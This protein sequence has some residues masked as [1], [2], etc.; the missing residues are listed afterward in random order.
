MSLDPTHLA[1]LK[2]SANEKE[3]SYA[4][5]ILP[6][7]KHGHWVL[8]TLLL[9]NVVVN[10][11]LPIVFDDIIGGGIAAVVISTALVVLFGDAVKAF[12]YIFYP[13]AYPI[14]LL[15][16]WILGVK[17]GTVYRRDELKAL[18]TLHSHDTFH[19]NNSGGALLNADQARMISS[20]L[21]VSDT[22]V[23]KIMT[24]LKD[25]FMLEVGDVIDAEVIKQIKLIPH[26]HIPIYSLHR[27]NVIGI[28]LSKH[29]IGFSPHTNKTPRRVRDFP[30][31]RLTF[32]GE[33]MSVMSLLKVLK[34]GSGHVAA[35]TVQQKRSRAPEVVGIVTREDLLEELFGEVPSTPL[36][37]PTNLT[38]FHPFPQLTS[39]Q[40]HS[41]PSYGAVNRASTCTIDSCGSSGTLSGDGDSGVEDMS[42]GEERRRSMDE[43]EGERA[44]L[45]G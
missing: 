2:T 22:T 38:A 7:R 27:S 18:V 31:T 40:P 34:A 20:V 3:R 1:I 45:L 17:H 28:L 39:P 41:D 43:E 12:M 11:T 29:L 36:P 37:V 8:S 15:L 19:H 4:E 16:D 23:G 42:A 33:R 25:V 13:V 24:P 10:E 5:R 35:V 14:S 21:D 9:G 32:V 26:P 44:P 6:I 30:M